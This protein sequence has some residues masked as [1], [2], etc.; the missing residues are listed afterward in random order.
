M[1]SVKEFDAWFNK[2][3][4]GIDTRDVAFAAWCA[5]QESCW[6]AVSDKIKE[7]DLGGTGNDAN[8]ERNGIVL[9]ANVIRDMQVG[10]GE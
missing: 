10:G 6:M 9:A 3:P 1:N 4:L 8:A 5:S 7:G 2:Y